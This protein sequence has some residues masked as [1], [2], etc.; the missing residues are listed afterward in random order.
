MR[1]VCSTEP[2]VADILI[3][4]QGSCLICTWS[5]RSSKS[6]LS[7]LDFDVGK[8]EVI[9]AVLSEGIGL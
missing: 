1:C 3:T 4:E 9:D 8:L 2:V 6:S 5:L 7:W